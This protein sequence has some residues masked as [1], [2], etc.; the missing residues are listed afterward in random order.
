MNCACDRFSEQQIAR[1]ECERHAGKTERLASSSP[2]VA[3]RV[4]DARKH[5]E[6]VSAEIFMRVPPPQRDNNGPS[7][8]SVYVD[9]ASVNCLASVSGVTPR[10]QPKTSRSLKW[11]SF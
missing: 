8:A 2:D 4:E 6:R 10:N 7:G 11:R 5:H 1:I 3:L 9:R